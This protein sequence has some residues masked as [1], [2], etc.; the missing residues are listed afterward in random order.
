VSKVPTHGTEVSTSDTTDVMAR[1]SSIPAL[2]V[3]IITSLILV[4]G[5]VVGLQLASVEVWAARLRGDSVFVSVDSR[6]W[7]IESGQEIYRIRVYNLGTEPLRIVGST[8]GCECTRIV[9]RPKTIAVGK[10]AD[11]LAGVKQDIRTSEAIPVMLFTDNERVPRIAVELPAA[12][13]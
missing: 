13:N 8:A 5:V 10:S 12:I 7:K 11:L 1:S 6:P 4:A 2:S 3:G 9:E